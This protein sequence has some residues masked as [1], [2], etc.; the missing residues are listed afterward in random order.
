MTD[1]TEKKWRFTGNRTAAAVAL[2]IV[3]GALLFADTLAAPQAEFDLKPLRDPF[4]PVGYFPE[5]WDSGETAGE[6]QPV[7]VSDWDAP[8]KL[9][10]ISGTSRMGSQTAAIINGN[11]KLIGDLVEIHYSGRIYQWKLTDVSPDGR[12]KLERHAVKKE[13]AG[14]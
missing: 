13:A 9:L 2:L 3:N 12:V 11:V 14:L 1:R 6:Q 8:A 7:T 10:K 4:W 5:N